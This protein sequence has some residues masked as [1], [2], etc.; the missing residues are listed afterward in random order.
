MTVMNQRLN[1]LVREAGYFATAVC[2]LYDAASG[3]IRSV[4]A[5]HPP[6][7]LLRA[8]GRIQPLGNPQ[9]ALGMLPNSSYTDTADVLSPGDALCLFTD[10]AIELINAEDEELGLEGLIQMLQNQG[11]GSPA[12]RC[13][14][15]LLE[16]QLLRFSN[17]IHL[18]D[19]LT[20]LKLCR[21]R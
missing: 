1:T 10:G 17:Q 12:S 9:P 4:R 3:Q 16:E 21:H 18:P 6:P 8:D 2:V 15:Q 20:L 13:R 14:L 5:G 11:S 19:D 7:L